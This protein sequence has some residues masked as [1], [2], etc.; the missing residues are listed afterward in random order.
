MVYTN[1]ILSSSFFF[2][3]HFYADR[4][5]PAV[6]PLCLFKC[7]RRLNYDVSPI[8]V[9]NG[10]GGEIVI[11]FAEKGTQVL[12]YFSSRGSSLVVNSIY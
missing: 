9:L 7:F 2:H 4:A 11:G 12:N 10:F 1:C 6:R 8:Y 3:F 5:V